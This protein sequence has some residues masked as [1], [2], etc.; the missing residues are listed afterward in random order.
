[1][2]LRLA[3]SVRSAF[4]VALVL[5]VTTVATA[6]GPAPAA[7]AATCRH[8]STWTPNFQVAP[9]SGSTDTW[10]YGIKKETQASSACNDIVLQ[11]ASIQTI[12][13]GGEFFCANFR[14]RYFNANGTTKSVTTPLGVCEG[15]GVARLD[16]SVANGMTYRVESNGNFRFD[17]YD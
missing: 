17:M 6:V 10:Y 1:M 11:R 8:Y 3:K 16:T 4:L 9:A 13:E 2:R 15:T 12:M 14:V 5:A 7:S